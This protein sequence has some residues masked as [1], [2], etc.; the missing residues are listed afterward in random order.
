MTVSTRQSDPRDC[1]RHLD[2]DSVE[3]YR[4]DGYLAPIAV[5]DET[6]MAEHRA[7]LDAIEAG[8]PGGRI[9]PV[10]NVKI[11]L[12]APYLWD[13]VRHP[14]VVDPVESLLGPD[15]LC[16]AA[17]FFDKRPDSPQHVP[18]HQDATYWGLSA[19]E[20]VTAWIAFTPSTRANGCMRVSPGTHNAAFVH[21]D[22]GDN[23]AMLPGR[24]KVQV[25]VDEAHAV[26]IE[27]RPGEMSLHDVL[28]VHGSRANSSAQRRCGLSIRYIPAHLTST[29]PGRPTATLVRGRDH[30]HFDLEERPDATFGPQ[31]IQRYHPVARRWMRAVMPNMGGGKRVEAKPS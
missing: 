23:T 1:D 16:W 17:G 12:L 28:L 25:E 7:R 20:A 22:T 10:H 30:G 21:A 24:E 27:L 11:H 19:P 18:W 2:A 14:A 8:R 6:E 26:D 13:L 15:I 4:R 31:A 3:R 9:S 29:G 5:T